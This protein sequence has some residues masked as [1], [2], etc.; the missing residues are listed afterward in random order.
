MLASL[1]VRSNAPAAQAVEQSVAAVLSCGADSEARRFA[2]LAQ[3]P[4]EQRV[5]R[6]AREAS[7]P[8]A[9]QP[10][11]RLA[12]TIDSWGVGNSEEG[13]RAGFLGRFE[14]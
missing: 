2:G 8:L 9:I 11:V 13:G 14:G 1:I 10:L 12:T 5:R 3:T 6:A 7:K 4:A